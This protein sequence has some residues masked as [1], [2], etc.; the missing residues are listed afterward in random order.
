MRSASPTPPSP[1][2][3]LRGPWRTCFSLPTC[4]RA[5]L[6]LELELEDGAAAAACSTWLRCWIDTDEQ[7]RGLRPAE[8]G[9]LPPGFDLEHVSGLAAHP[10][11]EMMAIMHCHHPGPV[12]A[13]GSADPRS[14]CPRMDLLLR[15]PPFRDHDWRRAHHQLQHRFL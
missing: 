15:G 5:S 11:G 3:S 2:T 6:R 9:P 10:S 7:R 14:L 4:S 8:L 12:A 13:R 1:S